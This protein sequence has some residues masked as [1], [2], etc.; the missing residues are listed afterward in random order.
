MGLKISICLILVAALFLLGCASAPRSNAAADCSKIPDS[1][2][3]LF[4]CYA[5]LALEKGSVSA[6]DSIP[7]G[8][9]T[10]QANVK[11]CR[12]WLAN[13]CTCNGKVESHPAVCKEVRD[14]GVKGACE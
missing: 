8:S 2:T 13:E 6:C 10:Q 4:S 12:E 3:S 11:L 14:M 1:D 7:A 5:N 9:N